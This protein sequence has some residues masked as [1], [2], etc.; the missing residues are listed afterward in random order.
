MKFRWAILYVENVQETLDFYEAAF[1]FKA[2]FIT[3]SG[4]YGEL[5]TESTTLAFAAR[6][7]IK[8]MGKN[9]IAPDEARPSFELAFE[10]DDVEGALDRAVAAGATLTMPATKQDWGQTISYVVDPN[11]FLIEVCTPV[12]K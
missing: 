4:D 5:E 12:G 3:E 11:G 10:T 1:G 8:E 7:M 6:Q 9:P 2:K